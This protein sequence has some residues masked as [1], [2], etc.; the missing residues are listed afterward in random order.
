M[1]HQSIGHSWLE[2]SQFC[3]FL[4]GTA[5]CK[6][7]PTHIYIYI[8]ICIYIYIICLLF[9]LIVYLFT[10]IWYIVYPHVYIYIY[11]CIHKCVCVCLRDWVP[12]VPRFQKNAIATTITTTQQGIDGSRIMAALVPAP[13]PKAGYTGRPG[14]GYNLCNFSVGKRMKNPWYL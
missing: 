12:K 5:N 3:P 6:L 8:I 1:A 14:H 7:T 11:I 2:K 4:T 9:H 13:I 10:V